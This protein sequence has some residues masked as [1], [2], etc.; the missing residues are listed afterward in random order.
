M[1]WSELTRSVQWEGSPSFRPK[2]RLQH[3]ALDKPQQYYESLHGRK[4]V[5]T[6]AFPWRCCSISDGRRRMGTVRC[7]V[8]VINDLLEMYRRSIKILE[9]FFNSIAWRQAQSHAPLISE[10]WHLHI[11]ISCN[12]LSS[13]VIAAL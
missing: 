5:M 12:H 4:S 8:G 10:N 1:I 6:D 9:I 11:I 2:T 3:L 13:V 7:D